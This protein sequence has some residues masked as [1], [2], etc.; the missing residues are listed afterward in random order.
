MTAIG[1]WLKQI[2]LIVMFAVIA[3]LLLPNKEMQRYVRMVLGLA[4]V[5]AMLQPI[6]AIVQNGWSDRLANAAASEVMAGG[7]T[8]ASTDSVRHFQSVLESEQTAEANRFLADELKAQIET[9][10]GVRVLSVHVSGRTGSGPVS[11]TITLADGDAAREVQSYV[12]DTM[13][14]TTN[15]VTVTTTGGGTSNGLEAPER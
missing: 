14:I 10:F 15:R 6:H 12:A 3:D 9:K 2:I 8:D 5:A 7:T 11:V 1:E 13:D 4:V